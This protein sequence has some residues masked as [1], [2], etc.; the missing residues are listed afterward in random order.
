LRQADG[1]VVKI[2]TPLLPYLPSR[3]HYRIIFLD[4]PIDEI[5]ASQSRMR[6]RRGQASSADV[7]RLHAA[8]SAHKAGTLAQLRRSKA[9][10]LLVVPY[11]ELVDQPSEWSARI[12]AFVGD[13]I[14]RPEKMA[15]AVRPDL[16]RNRLNPLGH[17]EAVS[18]ANT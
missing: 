18:G 2:V 10:Q 12:A 3:H 17:P 8:L 4:R 6:D 5:V 13:Q 1:K 15:G 9:I 11:P 16:Y 7:S 14:P